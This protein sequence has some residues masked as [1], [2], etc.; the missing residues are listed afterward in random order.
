M[1]EPVMQVLQTQ[2]IILASG[3]PRR[4]EILN[5]VV[6]EK[7]ELCLCSKTFSSVMLI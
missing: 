5:A 6:S 1:L 4:V 2:K 3:S 7:I